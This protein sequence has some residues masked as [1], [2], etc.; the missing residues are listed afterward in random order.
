MIYDKSQFYIKLWNVWAHF[1]YYY[2]GGKS[3]IFRYKQERT[4][5]YSLVNSIPDTFIS[6]EFKNIYAKL[7]NKKYIRRDIQDLRDEIKIA[8]KI[9]NK[10]DRKHRLAYLNLRYNELMKK[11]EK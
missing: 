11:Y 5:P 9:V 10:E 4:G 2:L 3:K 1:K 7:I 6:K 8:R